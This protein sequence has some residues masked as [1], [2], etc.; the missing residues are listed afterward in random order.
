MAISTVPITPRPYGGGGRKISLPVKANQQLYQGTMVAYYGGFTGALV[1]ATTAGAG[2]AIGIVEFDALGG[3]SDGTVRAIVWTDHTFSFLN[4]TNAFNDTTAPG[5][6]AY[7]EDDHTVGTGGVGGT[8]E[9]AAGVFMGMNDDGTVR[10]YMFPNVVGSAQWIAANGTNLANTATQTVPRLS[11]IT[12]YKFPTIGQN[13][14]VTLSTTGAVIGDVVRIVR[15]DTSA[16]TLAVANGGAG[17]G[18]LVTLV[19]SKP[20]FVQAYFD[21]TNW[22]YDGSAQS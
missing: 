17:A 3:A 7:C 21:G 16:F 22:N 6:L 4:G 9:A 15:T 5:A 20:G 2:V 13:S 10:V 19:A 12:R 18:T 11:R 8:G 1:P 14:T